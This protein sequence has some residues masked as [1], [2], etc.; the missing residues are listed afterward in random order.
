ML[1]DYKNPKD[2]SNNLER[3]TST[4]PTPSIFSLNNKSLSYTKTSKL[5]T[6]LYMVTDIIEK[7]EPI[8]AKLRTLSVEVL[9]DI[10]N[11]S[12]N[13]IGHIT[14]T[15]SSIMSFFNIAF[16]MG[17]ISEMNYRILIKEFTELRNSVQGHY[18]KESEWLQEFMLS[19]TSS[20]DFSIGHQNS[21]GM[22]NNNVLYNNV[23]KKTHMSVIKGQDVP[24][25][26]GI[27]IGVQK[28][29]TLLNALDKVDVKDFSLINRTA[30]FKEL[31]NKRRGDIIYFIKDKKATTGIDGAT[32]TD[33]KT[34]GQGTLLSCGEKTLQRELV[35]MVRDGI[36][37]KKGDKRWS[38]Y[39]LV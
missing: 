23:I 28:G 11:L 8:R 9:S 37:S 16:D 27:R 21:V 33:I 15:I 3:D 14:N 25:Q 22:E 24:I 31:K 5:I 34:G 39:F 26:S 32:I 19:N 6:A 17:M 20:N 7:D 38:Q 2:I 35:S 36:L 30:N 29:S 1:G 12:K 10:S 13:I 18:Q 4:V